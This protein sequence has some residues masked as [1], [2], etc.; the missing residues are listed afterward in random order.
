MAISAGGIGVG[1]GVGAGVEVGEG[2]A[3]GAGVS[4]GAGVAVGSG[5]MT[6]HAIRL[7][8]RSA[9]T[10]MLGGAIEDTSDRHWVRC[11]RFFR[12]AVV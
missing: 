5:E 7:T 4:V 10:I 12:I 2:V 3:V 11:G 9:S 8:V 6:V 1:V